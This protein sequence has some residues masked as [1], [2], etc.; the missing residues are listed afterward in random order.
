[1]DGPMTPNHHAGYPA[2][3]GFSGAIAA[4]SMSFGRRESAQLAM[5]LSEL[6]PGQTIIDIGCGP[7]AAVRHAA[8]TGAIAI[9]VDP[10]P[11][12]LRM[13]RFLTRTSNGV[14]YVKGTAEA[15]PVP[16]DSVSVAWSIATVHHWSDLEAGLR[17]VQRV[18]TSGGRF[19]AVERCSRAGARGHGSHGWTEEQALLFADRCRALGFVDVRL[20]TSSIG[21]RP[22]VS[23]V[24]TAA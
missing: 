17:E 21:R 24:A 6:Q 11:V 8:R 9:G 16:E 7:G 1:M 18:L 4:L 15:L 20:E 23:V 12:M 10:A 19:V 14:R 5:G 13:A 22:A 2:F 3:A